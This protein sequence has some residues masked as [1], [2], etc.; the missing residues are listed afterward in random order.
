MVKITNGAI[1]ME[2]PVS[3]LQLYKQNGWRET[4]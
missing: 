4:K 3:Q 1:I 2:V